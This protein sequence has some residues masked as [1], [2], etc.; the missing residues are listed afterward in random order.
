MGAQDAR[1]SEC[2]VVMTG[3]GAFAP[4]ESGQT[5]GWSFRVRD[6]GEPLKNGKQMNASACAP[7]RAALSWNSLDWTRI[8]AAV[9][10]L[11]M[12]IAQAT[13]E[14]RWGKLKA[15]QRLLTHS[16]SGKALAV[17]RVTDNRGK[18]TPGVDK[19]TWL[20]ATSKGK[21]IGMLRTHGYR[22]K[23]LR[24]YL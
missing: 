15:L 1:K 3:I 8:T 20:S 24:R 7:S 17:K 12:R 23:P 13:R 2:L 18:N 14:G 4:R 5:S 9:K 11:Q 6:F 22:A 10:R 19:V 16:F 21:A